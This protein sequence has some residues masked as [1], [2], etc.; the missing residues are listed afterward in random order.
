MDRES[1][2]SDKL[3]GAECN[4]THVMRD[5]SMQLMWVSFLII[6]INKDI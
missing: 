6:I 2:F 3:D 4:W 5:E 1:N